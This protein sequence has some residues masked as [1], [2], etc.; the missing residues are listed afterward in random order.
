MLVFS[1]WHI[2]I[3]LVPVAVVAI[4][5]AIIVLSQRGR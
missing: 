4:I 3:L 1:I 5:V 2:L